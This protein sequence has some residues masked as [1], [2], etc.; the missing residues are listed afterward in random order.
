M[1]KLQLGDY[2]DKTDLAGYIPDGN[3]IRNLE[4]I[5]TERGLARTAR[6]KRKF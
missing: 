6:F 3:A 4:K 1:M 2:H 5:A